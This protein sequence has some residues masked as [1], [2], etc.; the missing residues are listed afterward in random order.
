MRQRTIRFATYL[1]PNMHPVYERVVAYA[2]QRL[3]I[4]AELVTGKSFEDFASGDCDAGF[5]CGLPYVQ[6]TRSHPSP[7]ELLAA[8]VLQGERYGGHP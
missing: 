6:L 1:A 7:V 8:P 4:R 5:I 3:G 2:G